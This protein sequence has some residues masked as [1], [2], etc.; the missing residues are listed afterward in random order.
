M[1][2]PNERV[3]APQTS[4]E[5]VFYGKPQASPSSIRW[6]ERASKQLGRHIHHAL[7]G[8]GGER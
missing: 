6:L 4:Y 3:E 8:H 7:C 1:S 5:R 2:C